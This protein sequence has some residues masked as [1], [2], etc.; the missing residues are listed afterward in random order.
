MTGRPLG[1][2][3]KLGHGLCHHSH[4]NVRKK[5]IAVQ[6]AAELSRKCSNIV[7][8]LS[9][10]TYGVSVPKMISDNVFNGI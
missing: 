10:L 9:S 5:I 3:G 2:G 7:W 8:K 6:S 1:P 4:V